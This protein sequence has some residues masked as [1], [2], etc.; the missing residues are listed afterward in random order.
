VIR[1]RITRTLAWLLGVAL[2]IGGATRFGFFLVHSPA[3][4]PST[5]AGSVGDDVAGVTCLGYV[6]GDDGTVSLSPAHPGCVAE[7]L[8]HEG[9]S[10]SSGTVLLR[11]DDRPARFAREQAQAAREIAEVRLEQAQEGVRQHASRLAQQRAGLDAA[12]SRLA[13]A[14][15]LLARKKELL[16]V[17]LAHTREIA[18]AEEQVNELEAVSRGEQEKLAELQRQ[19]AELQVR[20]AKADLFAS[21]ARLREADYVLDQC[22]LKA[23]EAGTVLR[24]LVGR[25][26]ILGGAPQ[27]AVLFRPNGRRV[28][29]A[30][31]EQ[32]FIGRVAV[33]QTA[34]VE[35]EFA[36]E[37]RW[38]GRVIRIA[39]R[40]A[41]RRSLT[42]Q[43]PRFTDVPTVECVIALDSEQ[44]QLR[45]G[46]RVRVMIGSV[47][48]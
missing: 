20:S 23:P 44:P 12:R 15:H 21:Q 8:I 4:A 7:I 24:V 22:V 47:L 9:D 41:E 17:D 11:L 18:A 2:L 32:E 13:A 31:V 43:P 29:R 10:V 3:D 30:E 48:P 42:Q 33:G 39:E 40:Y 25:G 1:N 26:T 36:H 28:I 27:S 34:L 37:G 14:R 38:S 6:D 5:G 16:E 35:D 19:D 45:F 46:Q